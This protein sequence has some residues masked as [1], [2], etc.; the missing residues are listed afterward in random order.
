MPS[1]GSS[2]TETSIAPFLA[3]DGAGRHFSMNWSASYYHMHGVLPSGSA[4]FGASIVQGCAF[5]PVIVVSSL[6]LIQQEDRL[7]FFLRPRRHARRSCLGNPVHCVVLLPF[8]ARRLTLPPS[9]SIH[10]LLLPPLPPLLLPAETKRRQ[11][12]SD[13]PCSLSMF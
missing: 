9:A 6:R 10:L 5:D 1:G 3:L 4:V 2:N 13:L 8:V 7:T 12:R 11:R